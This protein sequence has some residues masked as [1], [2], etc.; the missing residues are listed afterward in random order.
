[1]DLNYTPEEQAFRAE[2]RAFVT[3]HLPA[4]RR[5]ERADQDLL[6]LFAI[7]VSAAIRNA[8]LYARVEAQNRRLVNLDDSQQ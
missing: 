3:G 7:E 2:V 6:D 8:Q 1:M 4:T 5:W